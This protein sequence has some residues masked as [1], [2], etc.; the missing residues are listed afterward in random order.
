MLQKATIRFY[1]S[2]A[3]KIPTIWDV[4]PLA[5]QRMSNALL[6]AYSNRQFGVLIRENLD[7][8]TDHQV[9]YAFQRINEL[10]LDADED[11]YEYVLPALKE[12]VPNLTKDHPVSIATII[13][14]CGKI[15]VKDASLW[16]LFEKKI[17]AD[18]L[19]RYIPLND[20]VS[21]TQQVALS[22]YG[23]EGFFNT[24]EKQ[25]GRHRLALSDEQIKLTQEAFERKRLAAPIIKQLKQSAQKQLA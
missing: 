12:F 6:G 5:Y 17:V 3:R 19:Y 25:I 16:Q 23:S 4:N 7:M 8:I 22:D 21:M 11:F 24:M 13:G 9:A 15:N 1:L 14:T 10:N 2:Q 18:R 20:L